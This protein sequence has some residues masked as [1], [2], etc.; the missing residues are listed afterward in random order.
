LNGTASTDFRKAYSAEG[1]E[2]S[3]F[4]KTRYSLRLP[5]AEK[6]AAEKAE[7]EARE[8]AAAGETATE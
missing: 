4:L 2:L 5:S 7:E 8:A 3:E 1:D 6:Y